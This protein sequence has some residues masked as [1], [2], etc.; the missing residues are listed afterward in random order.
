M[1]L[2]VVTHSDLLFTVNYLSHYAS[3][4]RKVHWN[5]IKHA[6][7]YVKSTIN[8]RITYHH[9]ARLQL[10]SFVDSNYANDQDTRRSMSRYIFY[11]CGGLGS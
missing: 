3:N 11:I 5:T 8:Y 2:Q 4:P 9:K 6:I 7:T 1:W 10:V